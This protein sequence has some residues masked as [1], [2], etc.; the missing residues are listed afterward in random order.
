[1]TR[2]GDVT[3]NLLVGVAGLLMSASSMAFGVFFID[4]G[5][6]GIEIAEFLSS[7]GIHAWLTFL[8][9]I[10]SV[11]STLAIIIAFYL[12]AKKQPMTITGVHDG[13]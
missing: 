10:F 2:R 9:G 13:A 8:M 12:P 5:L 6:R 7:G 1:M 11:L 3:F 4:R